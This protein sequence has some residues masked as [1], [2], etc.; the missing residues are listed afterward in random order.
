M[1]TKN[2][3]YECIRHTNTFCS[4][5]CYFKILP[6]IRWRETF[7]ANFVRDVGVHQSTKSKTIIPTGAEVCD[8]DIAVTYG[9]V[10]TPLEQCIP[11][12]A[13]TLSQRSQRILLVYDSTYL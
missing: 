4:R 3:T 9:L 1:I 7:V 10:L 5:Y 2:Y 12:G 13:T 8:V 11:L 6:L